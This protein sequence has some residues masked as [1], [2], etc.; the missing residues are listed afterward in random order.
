MRLHAYL[1]QALAP[2]NEK[3]KFT[4]LPHIQSGELKSLGVNATIFED[5]VH[6]LEAKNDSRTQDVKKALKTWGR[7][8]LVDASFKGSLLAHFVLGGVVLH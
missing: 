3:L 5:L 7:L 4:Q 1:A 6:V 2:G 8:D